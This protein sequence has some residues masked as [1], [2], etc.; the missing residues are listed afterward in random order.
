MGSTLKPDFKKQ[1]TTHARVFIQ[2]MHQSIKKGGKR[3]IVVKVKTDN[4]GNS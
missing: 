4:Y 1:K 3:N 2:R